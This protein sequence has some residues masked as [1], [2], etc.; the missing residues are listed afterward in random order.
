MKVVSLMLAGSIVLLA[1]CS[2]KNV[3]PEQQATAA[4][5]QPVHMSVVAMDNCAMA[6]GALAYTRQLD[7]SRI[8]MCQLVN[9]KRCSEAALINGHCAR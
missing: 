5:I 7:G 9:G 1:G 3:E 6:G 8:G 4:H 2:H